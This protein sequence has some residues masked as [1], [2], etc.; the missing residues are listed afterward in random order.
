MW[1]MQLTEPAKRDK[2]MGTK[3]QTKFK[4]KHGLSSAQALQE[5]PCK[6]NGFC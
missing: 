3:A 2:D 4:H 1:H 6:P 5:A